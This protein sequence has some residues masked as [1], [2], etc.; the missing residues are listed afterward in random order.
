MCAGSDGW[1]VMGSWWVGGGGVAEVVGV[2][3]GQHQGVHRLTA[4]YSH[5]ESLAQ[6]L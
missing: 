1:S 6:A 4:R 5:S 3:P 2:Q